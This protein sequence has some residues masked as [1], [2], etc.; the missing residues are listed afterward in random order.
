MGDGQLTPTATTLGQVATIP[1]SSCQTQGLWV[2]TVR[3]SFPMSGSQGA[4]SHPICTRGRTG[5]SG[6]SGILPLPQPG[7]LR[8]PSNSLPLSLHPGNGGG[9]SRALTQAFTREETE[10]LRG[11]CRV[12]I[13]TSPPA[14][15]LQLKRARGLQARN[16]LH[17]GELP[18]TGGIKRP[19]RPW[20]FGAGVHTVP[21]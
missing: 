2:V 12:R 9:H 10:A 6:I 21:A 14:F 19:R 4:F 1:Y 18:G 20:G 7:V 11:L 13:D 5:P 17:R 8:L 16:D 15:S 3:G